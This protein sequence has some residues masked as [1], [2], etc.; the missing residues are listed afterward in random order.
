M[1]ATPIDTMSLISL[2]EIEDLIEQNDMNFNMDEQSVSSMSSG[3]KV[4]LR[5]EAMS[6]KQ[7]KGIIHLTC[8][9]PSLIVL[10]RLYNVPDYIKDLAETKLKRPVFESSFNPNAFIRNAITGVYTEYKVGSLNED[11]FFKV[12]YALG[13]DGRRDPSIL[14]FESPHQYEK[15]LFDI[16]SDSLKNRWTVRRN[17]RLQELNAK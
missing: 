15:Y 9:V 13:M 17:K 10:E 16:V 2:A 14:F 5:K 1:S 6:Q 7:N 12:C 11:L 4:K 8:F 3:A